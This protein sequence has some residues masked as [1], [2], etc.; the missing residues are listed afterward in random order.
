MEKMK[1]YVDGEYI[2]LTDKEVTELQQ[3]AQPAEQT[4]EERLAALEALV[5]ERG[6]I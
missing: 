6:I 3:K 1:R 2:Q 4:L 5:V